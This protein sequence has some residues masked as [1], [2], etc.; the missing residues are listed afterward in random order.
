MNILKKAIKEAKELDT[1]LTECKTPAFRKPTPPPKPRTHTMYGLNLYISFDDLNTY[2][3]NH[4]GEIY[5]DH[6]FIP[7]KAEVNELGLGIDIT[8][9]SANPIESDGRR[10]KLDLNAIAEEND[11]KTPE[12]G[13]RAKTNVI[14]ETFIPCSECAHEDWDM[15][16]CKECNATNNFKYFEGWENN[17]D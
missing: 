3:H 4:I 7:V 12:R 10:Y 16:Q 13:L 9:M 1:A 8:L 14:D 5:E 6:T 17:N 2:I 11:K 15:P